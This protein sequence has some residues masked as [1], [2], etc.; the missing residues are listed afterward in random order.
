MIVYVDKARINLH[1]GKSRTNNLSFCCACLLYLPSMYEV[2]TFNTCTDYID[3]LLCPLP[4]NWPGYKL[5]SDQV[6]LSPQLRHQQELFIK[7]SAC[8]ST[9]SFDCSTLQLH[10]SRHMQSYTAFSIVCLQTHVDRLQSR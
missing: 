7:P 9:L 6:P 4:E 3:F 1:A 2:F 5:C 10:N 8:Y